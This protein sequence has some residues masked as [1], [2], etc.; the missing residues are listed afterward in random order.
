MNRPENSIESDNDY[1]T[2]A[3]PFFNK[4]DKSFGAFSN[5]ESKIIEAIT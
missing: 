2:L 3:P 4:S 1:L 5:F